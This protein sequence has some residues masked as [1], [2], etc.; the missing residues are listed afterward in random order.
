MTI[1][2]LPPANR[3]SVGSSDFSSDFCYLRALAARG[4]LIMSKAID[5]KRQ[6]LNGM[7]IER[8]EAAARTLRSSGTGTQI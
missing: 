3:R 4:R 5:S 1:V 8:C 2:S 6:T 7:R